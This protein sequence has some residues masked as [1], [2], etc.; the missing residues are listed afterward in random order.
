[1]RYSWH[2]I[3]YPL[4]NGGKR[5]YK[6]IAPYQGLETAVNHTRLVLVVKWSYKQLLSWLRAREHSFLRVCIAQL[7][8]C[9]V[10]YSWRK[11][12]M[13][14]KLTLTANV[15]NVCTLWYTSCSSSSSCLT[16]PSIPSVELLNAL[17]PPQSESFIL[18]TI[19]KYHKPNNYWS[20]WREVLFLTTLSIRCSSP[21]G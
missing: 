21:Q 11:C 4:S 5:Q 17:T 1:M 2:C 19:G 13:L 12:F 15:R 16:Y 14:V 6:Y 9:V 10:I 8:V 18:F 20:V 7:P 3:L